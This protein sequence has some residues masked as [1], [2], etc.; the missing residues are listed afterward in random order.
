MAYKTWYKPANIKKYIGNPNNI[1]CRSLWERNVCKFLDENESIVKWSS[2]EIAIP[3]THPLDS[4]IHNY[5]PDFMVQ[6][7]NNG[8][9]QTW[10]IEI[11]PKKQTLLRE[12]ATKNEKIIWSV[13][14]A[15]WTAAKNYCEKNNIT[16]KILT[17]QELFSNA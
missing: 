6:F 12:N 9:L 4:K 16:F 3:Y 2:E 14:T 15:K 17:E 1:V 8:G 13:N 10:I 5:Y 11:K 7:K